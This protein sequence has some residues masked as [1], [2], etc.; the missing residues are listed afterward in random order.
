MLRMQYLCDQCLN[1]SSN[2]ITGIQVWWSLPRVS[3]YSYVHPMADALDILNTSIMFVE[4][5]FTY[6]P[7]IASYCEMIQVEKG[8]LSWTCQQL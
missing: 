7:H 1:G 4:I 6:V 8:F 2:I 3:N 5:H